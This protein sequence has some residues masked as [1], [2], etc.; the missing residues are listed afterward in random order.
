[1]KMKQKV[2]L[3][4][5]LL[6]TLSFFSIENFNNYPTSNENDSENSIGKKLKING[7]WNLTGSPIWIDGNSEW[8][9]TAASED[10]CRGSGTYGDP[11][12]L[13]D[14]IIDGQGSGDCIII[15]SCNVYFIIRDCI[16]YNAGRGIRLYSVS[17]GI[18]SENTIS[19]LTSDGIY[20]SNCQN[21]EISGN[22]IT[23]TIIAVNLVSD[24]EDTTI[25]E[26]KIADNVDG[27][28][29]HVP[30]NLNTLLYG[31]FFLRNTEH[32]LDSGMNSFWNNS[33]IGNYWDDYSGVD[34]DFNGIGDNVYPNCSGIDYL[35]IYDDKKPLV[36]ILS[37][38][39]NQIFS[40]YPPY[41]HIS[42]D[43]P[44]LD[45]TWYS[46]DNGITNT[47]FNGFSGVIDTAQWSTLPN[48]PINITFYAKDKAEY[49]GF[50]D[51]YIRKNAPKPSLEAQITDQVFFIHE[52]NFTV[53][54]YNETNQA[55]EKATIQMWW[56][57][58]DFSFLVQNLGSGLYFFSLE[59]ITVAPEE[60]PIL[61]SMTISAD[62]YEDLY[63]DTYI[64]VDPIVI[65]K[66]GEE[67]GVPITPMWMVFLMGL[68]Y[69][70]VPAGLIGL[71]IYLNKRR[72]KA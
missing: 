10:W 69:F 34:S 39:N 36:S 44:Y 18:I 7:F 58:T 49:E 41:F 5:I 50:R 61:L 35:P 33:E 55:I 40:D 14:I 8:A 20:F 63:Y 57:G 21:I 70:G 71:I 29:I 68:L 22:T 4:L 64:A 59:P 66:Y 25:I 72:K 31:N 19:Q 15:E 27:V 9:T 28:Y 26:N 6:C 11:Y 30:L 12:I 60:D 2:M 52:F 13:E 65:Q 42:I 23:D 17:H 56:D 51:V 16:L 24:N 43:E 37:P 32:A 45:S 47:T 62:G 53:Y 46:L 48:G 67:N 3:I 1:M 54:V 38:I